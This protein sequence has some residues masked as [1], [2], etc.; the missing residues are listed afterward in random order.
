MKMH[1]CA[2]APGKCHGN[3]ATC[4]KLH[5]RR[6]IDLAP[7]GGKAKQQIGV[8]KCGMCRNGMQNRSVCRCFFLGRDRKAQ[9]LAALTQ[10]LFF[11]NR[12]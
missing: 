5:D 10:A 9:R 4:G 7:N 11:Q 12:A 8:E 2:L 1:I 3:T 6:E